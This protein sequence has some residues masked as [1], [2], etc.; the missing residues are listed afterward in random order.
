[1]QFCL[2]QAHELKSDDGYICDSAPQCVTILAERHSVDPDARLENQV[3]ILCG[4]FA[5][6]INIAKQNKTELSSSIHMTHHE[7]IS[8]VA[9]LVEIFRDYPDAQASTQ[10][11]SLFWE[12]LI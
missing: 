5:S 10:V 12:T 4:I 9:N 1:M 2:I 7:N 11:S 8:S 3:S 6:K